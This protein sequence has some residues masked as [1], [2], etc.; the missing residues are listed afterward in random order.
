MSHKFFVHNAP[1]S[2]MQILRNTVNDVAN[3]YTRRFKTKSISSSEVPIYTVGIH[4]LPLDLIQQGVAPD[5]IVG[6]AIKLRAVRLTGYM[7]NSLPNTVQL[8]RAYVAMVDVGTTI[9][10]APSGIFTTFNVV[11][12]HPISDP[13]RLRCLYDKTMVINN[14]NMSNIYAY[15]LFEVIIEMDELIKFSPTLV[16]G[17]LRPVNKQISLGIQTN[18]ASPNN[19]VYGAYSYQLWWDDGHG[20]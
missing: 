11:Q 14:Y 19:Y 7:R 1:F 18:V 13:E 2:N 3:E 10:T 17:Y 4:S 5:E 6:S 8:A 15:Q 16:G 20:L 9:P 12:G